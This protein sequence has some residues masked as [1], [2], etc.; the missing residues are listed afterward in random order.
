MRLVGAVIGPGT[1]DTRPARSSSRTATGLA[2]P[3]PA[4]TDLVVECQASQ[5]LC[6][7][8]GHG[9]AARFRLR[10]IASWRSCISFNVISYG[11][12]TTAKTNVV[13]H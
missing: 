7:A 1:G 6:R 9:D 8:P 5:H 11:K 13:I 4:R 10:A 3:G 12:N 2:R